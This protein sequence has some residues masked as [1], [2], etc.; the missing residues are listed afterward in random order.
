ML[1][2][3]QEDSGNAMQREGHCK[4]G[5]SLP[6]VDGIGQNTALQPVSDDRRDIDNVWQDGGGVKSV[7]G[8]CIIRHT[9]DEAVHL[10]LWHREYAQASS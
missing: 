8:I 5:L 9:G 4:Q 1:G 3:Q 6:Y 7:H 10:I 2:R